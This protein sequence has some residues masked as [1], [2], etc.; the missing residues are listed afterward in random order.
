M[1]TF[2]VLA[3]LLASFVSL[4][5]AVP[6]SGTDAFHQTCLSFQPQ[7]YVANSSLTVREFVPANT[8]LAFPGN[9]ATCNRASQLVSADVCRIAMSIP[10]SERSNIIYEMWLPRTWTGRFLATGNGGIDGCKS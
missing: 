5:A 4:A 10:T 8:T 3:S 6:A 9:D 2:T 1:T 7:Q